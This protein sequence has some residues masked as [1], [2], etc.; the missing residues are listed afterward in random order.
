MTPG[1]RLSSIRIEAFRG[2]SDPITFDLTSPIT[3]IFAP[4]G[5]GKTTL[6][7]AAEWLLTGQVERLRDS[8]DFDPRV[9][10]SKFVNVDRNPLVNARIIVAD[11]ERRLMRSV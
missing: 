10:K 8:R 5:T 3:L 7:E 6:C 1:V 4:N 9:L 2:I 11:N